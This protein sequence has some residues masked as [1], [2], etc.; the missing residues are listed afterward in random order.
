VE[1]GRQAWPA[2]TSLISVF[3]GSIQRR[4]G[5]WPCLTLAKTEKSKYIRQSSIT[6]GRGVTGRGVY[7]HAKLILTYKMMTQVFPVPLKFQAG[8]IHTCF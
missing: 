7:N 4:R 1:Q 3:E 6:T 5:I 2:Q 8:M